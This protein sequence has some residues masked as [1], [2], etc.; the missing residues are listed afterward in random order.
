MPLH[1]C[2][3]SPGTALCASPFSDSS[4]NFK[5]QSKAVLLRRDSLTSQ[6]HSKPSP[7]YS[8]LRDIPF[9][10]VW[11]Q[12]WIVIHWCPESLG[13]G[14]SFRPAMLQGSLAFFFCLLPSCPSTL[15]FVSAPC[16]SLSIIF[17]C[18]RR[19]DYWP[20]SPPMERMASFP[21]FPKDSDHWQVLTTV[22]TSFCVML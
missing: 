11:W 7:P 5:A 12:L 22:L 6:I 14:H 1:S 2:F 18:A 4:I 17:S 3:L 16:K 21:L 9:W 15:L 13:R 8:G 20:T 10:H 19:P